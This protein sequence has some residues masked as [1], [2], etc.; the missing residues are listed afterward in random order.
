MAA[1]DAQQNFML[2]RYHFFLSILHAISLG[3]VECIKKLIVKGANIDY[4][5]GYVW[6]MTAGY[7]VDMLNCLFDRGID[8]DVTDQQ[9]KSLLWW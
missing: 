7:G 8:K 1:L 4:R 2:T 6:R 9:G 3:R 5:N